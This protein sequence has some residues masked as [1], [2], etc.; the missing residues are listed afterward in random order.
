MFVVGAPFHPKIIDPSQVVPITN[1][2]TWTGK[3]HLTVMR[4]ELQTIAFDC[5][6]AGPGLIIIITGYAID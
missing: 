1:N 5:K 2:E 3:D 6:N 4:N